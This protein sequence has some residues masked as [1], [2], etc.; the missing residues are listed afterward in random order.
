MGKERRHL[1]LFNKAENENVDG[2]ITY[3][4]QNV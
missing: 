1:C 4:N 2:I 3:I